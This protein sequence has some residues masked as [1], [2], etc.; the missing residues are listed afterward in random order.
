MWLLGLASEVII[1]GTLVPFEKKFFPYLK[2]KLKPVYYVS[3]AK[4]NDKKKCYSSLL[5]LCPS[6]Q[7]S[8]I[9]TLLI[10]W[11]GLLSASPT[12][13]SPHPPRNCRSRCRQHCDQSFQTLPWELSRPPSPQPP[14]L[15]AVLGD[16]ACWQSSL[17]A[18]LEHLVGPLSL[19]T[20]FTV[21]CQSTEL[22]L[23]MR[24]YV[25]WKRFHFFCFVNVYL[26]VW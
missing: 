26:F 18:A 5:R 10:M 2:C 15:P 25:G 4:H 11:E 9:L 7:N 6:V 20:L 19:S 22:H 12:V 13:T 1:L 14:G 21:L 8:V 3:R 17:T 23:L 16:P 24:K